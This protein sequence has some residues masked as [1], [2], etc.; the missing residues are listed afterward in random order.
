MSVT[1][2]LTSFRI[3]GTAAP[4]MTATCVGNFPRSSRSRSTVSRSC[5]TFLKARFSENHMLIMSNERGQDDVPTCTCFVASG[6]VNAY[7]LIILAHS[8]THCSI[9]WSIFAWVDAGWIF[10]KTSATFSNSN[11]SSITLNDVWTLS[12]RRN[13]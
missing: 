13:W 3:S 4:A 9:S 8:K 7:D 10:L 6:P 5:S 1:C 12:S 11:V 2:V